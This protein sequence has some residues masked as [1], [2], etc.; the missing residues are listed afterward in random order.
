MEFDLLIRGGLVVDGSGAPGQVADV[1]IQGGKIAAVGDLAGAVA[2]RV[3][4]AKGRVVAPGL[5]DVHVHS[6]LERLGGQEQFCG[7]L[8]GVTTELM[9]P[10]G[11]AWAPLSPERFAE[12]R[13]YLQ[14][15]YGDKLPAFDSGSPADFLA[16]F[17][18]RIPGN[19]VPQVPHLPIRVQVMGWA[20]RPATEEEIAQMLP[21]VR[22]WLDLGAVALATGLEYQPTAWSDLR[23]LVAL[24]R[25]VAER[26]GI[27]VTHQ[28][29]YWDHV[30]RGL[31]ET[32]AV[33]RE[34]GIPVHVSHLAV[35]DAAIGLMAEAV[36]GGSDLSFEMY[37]YP[38]SCTHLMMVLPGWAQSGGH[39][40]V[41]ARL[42]DSD[43]RSRM[44]EETEQSLRARGRVMLAG[45]D[46]GAEL[47]GRYL[48]ELAREAGKP[49]A[50]F[51]FDLLRAHGGRALVVYHWP[52]ERDGE[53]LLR[54]TVQHP[55][56]MGGSDGLYAAGRPHPRGF[57]TFARFLGPY[58]REGVLPLE[59][60]VH[61]LS[62]YPAERFRIKDRGLLRPGLAADVIVFDP[63]RLEDR[64][65]FG[66]GRQNPV[67]MET[68]LV[69]GV[70]AVA[71]GTPTGA[72]PGRVLA[73]L[74]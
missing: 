8:Q 71:G 24:S 14:V 12:V 74:A 16:Q 51:M 56:F 64:A 70:V 43:Q 21:L 20:Q 23:E 63:Q 65:T 50:E 41:M 66:M 2:G 49:M 34:A 55:L 15:F 17:A 69:N 42:A 1:G 47:E 52:P 73:P 6:E 13:D 48:D 5:I 67:G 40:A 26:G 62:G 44:A 57:G 18:G 58:V 25:P 39:A 19:V 54:R 60:M 61:K 72:L 59:Q 29:G 31:K 46:G 35:T 11:F 30:E 10:D 7:L 38:A 9:S 45:V 68:V 53:A 22:Q 36:A 32:I 27:Y 3:L 4:E 33:G 37:P 28:R